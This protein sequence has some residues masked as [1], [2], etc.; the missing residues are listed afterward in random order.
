MA[1][2]FWGA[3][4]ASFFNVVLYRFPLGKSVVRPGSA[5]PQCKKAIRFYDNIPIISWLILRGRCRGCGLGIPIRYLGVEALGGTLWVLGWLVFPNHPVRGFWL[6]CFLG[7]T[8]AQFTCLIRFRR[9]PWYLW[10][11]NVGLWVLGPFVFANP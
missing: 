1:L 11:F 5:C 4:W 6:G 2:F 7:L 8:T 3:C 9:A 10:T